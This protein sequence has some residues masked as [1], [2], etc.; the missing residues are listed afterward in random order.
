MEA[1]PTP[2]GHGGLEVS[3]R[4]VSSADSVLP[5]DVAALLAPALLR[6]FTQTRTRSHARHST[7]HEYQML[8]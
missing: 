5:E 4:R 1:M 7:P 8:L 3:A 2:T 6:T